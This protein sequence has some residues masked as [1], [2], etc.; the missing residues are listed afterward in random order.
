VDLSKGF[1]KVF[2]KCEKKF[3]NNE[4]KFQKVS[5]FREK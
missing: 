3:Q 2:E 5:Q 1:K 4:K